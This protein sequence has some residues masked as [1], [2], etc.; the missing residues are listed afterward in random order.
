MISRPLRVYLA[1]SVHLTSYR[2]YVKKEYSNDNRLEIV[3]PLEFEKEELGN[4]SD[5]KRTID[6]DFRLMNYCDVLT[7][8]IRLGPTFGTVSEIAIMNFYF[9]KP[10]YAFNIPDEYKNDPWLIGQ[11]IVFDKCKSCFDHLIDSVEN[12]KFDLQ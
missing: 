2:E 5:H 11:T 12:N 3:D 8:N 9:N 4:T 1:G 7:A 6:I 10:V